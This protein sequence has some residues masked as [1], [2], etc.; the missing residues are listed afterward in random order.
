[1]N[2]VTDTDPSEVSAAGLVQARPT[3][4]IDTFGNTEPPALN[5]EEGNGEVNDND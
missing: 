5:E 2:I 4:T 3:G 1:M